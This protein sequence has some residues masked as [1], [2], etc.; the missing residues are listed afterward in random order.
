MAINAQVTRQAGGLQY[1]WVMAIVLVFGAFMSILDQTVVN[2]AIPRL[3]SAFGTD[4]H[5]VQWVITAYLLTQGAMT[6]TTPFLAN[7]I[8]IT[9]SYILSLVPFTL[10]SVACGLS[11]SLPMLIFF[12]IVHGL[13]GD[14]LL[15]LSIAMLLREC[16]LQ[17]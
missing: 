3:Q 8:G 15:S 6:P 13:G 12:P 10:G 2:I 4:I 14:V 5:S 16:P 7:R 11:W 9:R 1:K 17:A